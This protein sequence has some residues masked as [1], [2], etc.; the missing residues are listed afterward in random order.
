MATAARTSR[1]PGTE[2]L[3]RAG[4]GFHML[5]SREREVLRLVAEGYTSAAI[6]DYLCLSPKTVDTYRERAAA[7]LGLHGRVDLVRFA[8]HEGLLKTAGD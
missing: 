4:I 3:E 8:L 5:S 1:R 6:G 2:P 7:K